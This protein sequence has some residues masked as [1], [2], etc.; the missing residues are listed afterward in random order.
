MIL[1]G[2]LSLNCGKAGDPQPSNVSNN[3]HQTGELQELRSAMKRIEPFFELMG[4]PERSDWMWSNHEPG[5]TFEDYLDSD[6]AK[7][8]AKRQKIYVLPLGK[9]S[10]AQQRAIDISAGYLA[11][12]YDLRVVEMP[13]RPLIVK[14]PHLRR[15]RSGKRQVRTG[16]ILEEILR[17]M[18]PADAA[19]LIAFTSED[20]YPNDTMNYVFGQA[21]F[22]DRV[23]VWSL[24]RL[25]D[26][27]DQRNFLLRTLKIP[28]HETGH[29]FGMR[30]CTKYECMMS[31]TNHL[32]ETD[33]RPLDA[34]P[35]CTAK[36]CWM[37]DISMTERYRQLISFCTKNGLAAEAMEFE[38]KLRAVSVID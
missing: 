3:N 11:V 33:R 14:G 35:E 15:S 26:N 36:I 27:T 9:F 34:C 1:A 8:T 32:G 2:I 19:A 5:Q 21:S 12:F 37:S 6:P 7:P 28:A 10:K 23:G 29:M 16:H 24:D 30:H 4:E 17:P 18:L 22:E 20:L 31:G 13:G 38:K 25:D